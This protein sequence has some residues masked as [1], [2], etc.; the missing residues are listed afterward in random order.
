[1]LIVI[2]RIKYIFCFSNIFFEPR[3]PGL[4]FFILLNLPSLF[5]QEASNVGSWL[6]M[7]PGESDTVPD[8]EQIKNSVV[9]LITS[10]FTIPLTIG[11]ATVQHATPTNNVLNIHLIGADQPEITMLSSGFFRE[12]LAML[13]PTEGVRLCF[14]SPDNGTRQIAASCTPYRPLPIYE[15]CTVVAYVGLY[16]DFWSDHVGKN[17][18]PPDIAILLHPGFH[19]PVLM[20][21]W[22]ETLQLLLD[23]NIPTLITTF[24][25]NEHSGTLEQLE[26]LNSNILYEGANPF[27]SELVKQTP[28]EADHIWASNAYYMQVKGRK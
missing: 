17:H 3:H 21:G 16:H 19:T 14:V 2:V 6:R 18:A 20:D 10:L 11:R 7:C 23:N 27:A 28:Y 22:N 9:R 15:G 25:E 4:G 13:P 24:N 5:F 8:N 12:L 1:M 26:K